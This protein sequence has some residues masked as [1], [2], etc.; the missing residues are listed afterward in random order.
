M[1][2]SSSRPICQICGYTVGGWPFGDKTECWHSS[3]IDEH[4][5]GETCGQ[6]GEPFLPAYGL[7]NPQKTYAI[8]RPARPSCDCDSLPC[9]SCGKPGPDKCSECRFAE[10]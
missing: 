7:L 6:C 1:K 5:T 10:L 8:N 4:S 9:T 2:E 3:I